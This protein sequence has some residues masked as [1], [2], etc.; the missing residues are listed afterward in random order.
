MSSNAVGYLASALVLAAFCM[1]EIIPLRIVA[2]CSNLAFIVYGLQLGL[3]PIWMLHAIL[4]PLNGWRL[5]QLA[6]VRDA[7][8]R[9]GHEPQAGCL[10][11]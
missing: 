9:R 1:K 3:A 4:L 7:E 5:W 2:L 8:R 10:A 11:R 6:R